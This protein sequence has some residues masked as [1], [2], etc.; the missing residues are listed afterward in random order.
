MGRKRGFAPNRMTPR[1]AQRIEERRPKRSAY[2]PTRTVPRS[3]PPGG[4]PLVSILPPLL[5]LENASPEAVGIICGAV[6]V[7]EVTGVDSQYPVARA[8]HRI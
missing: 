6:F 2:S 8:T 1:S 3:A 7:G 5:I 4:E